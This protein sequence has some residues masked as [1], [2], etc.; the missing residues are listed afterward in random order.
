MLFLKKKHHQLETLWYRHSQMVSSWCFVF[1]T[2]L[3]HHYMCVLYSNMHMLSWYINIKI[4]SHSAP[5]G[6]DSTYKPSGHSGLSDRLPENHRN[7]LV[8]HR[9]PYEIASC[10][11]YTTFPSISSIILLVRS[12]LRFPFNPSNPCYIQK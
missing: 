3:I 6:E 2:F 11:G 9:F 8:Y 5:F 4:P 7:H 10:L 1:F 12:P